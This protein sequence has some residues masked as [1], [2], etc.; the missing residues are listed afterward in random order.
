MALAFVTKTVLMFAR[1]KVSAAAIAGGF[2]YFEDVFAQSNVNWF[3]VLELYIAQNHLNGT[4]PLYLQRA[5][6]DSPFSEKHQVISRISLSMKFDYRSCIQQ[7]LST[8]VKAK[9]ICI[10]EERKALASFKQDFTDPSDSTTDKEWDEL[11]YNKSCLGRKINPSLLSL[12]HLHYLDLSCSNFEHIHIPNF[13]E[14][15]QTLSWIFNLISLKRLDLNSNSFDAPEELGNLKSL[16][17]LDLSQLGLKDSGVPR[18]LDLSDNQMNRSIPQSLGQLSKLLIRLDLFWNSWEGNI[19]EAHFINL[20]N[21]KRLSIGPD[22]DDREKPMSLIF[23]VSYDWV[24]PFKLFQIVITNCN[25]GPSF[26]V[27]LQSQTELADIFFYRTG[28]SDSIPEEWLLKLSSQLENLDLSYS[29]FRGRFS[30]NKWVRFPNLDTIS[31]AH[32]QFEGPV[33][34]WSTNASYFDLESNLFSG[35]IPSNFDKLMP[36]LKEMYLSENHLNGTIPPSICNMQD[37][38]IISLRSNHFFGKFPHAWSSESHIR[39]VDAAYNNLF[40]NIPTSMGELN[41]LEILKLNNNNFG[42][43]IPD[44]LHN[45]SVL[46]SIDLGG[47]KLSE[48]IPPWIGRSKSIDLSSN[49]LEGEI[50][51]EIC[52]LTVLGT[53]NLSRNQL[54]S[55]IPS[56]VGS[57]LLLKKSWRYAYFQFFDDTKDKV[58]LAIALKVARLQRKFHHV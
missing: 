35:P 39:I 28:I 14:K 19:T 4:I 20:T 56:I 16:E 21:L 58:T 49:F 46:K 13:F 12:K 44:S 29:Q 10:E 57:T 36:K 6:H 2:F 24:P 38:K 22:L 7:S 45:C 8:A 51:Q 26:G 48:S 25:V 18:Y 54:T 3:T 33:P 47:N 11:A 17:Y 55:N 41:S 5:K 23:N 50:P 15:L 34:L 40:G 42:G 9:S 31:L 1:L 43:Q 52:S 27:W 32:N 53:L 37:L 30:S